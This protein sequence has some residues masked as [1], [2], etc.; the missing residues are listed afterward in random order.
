MHSKRGVPA[1][2]LSKHALILDDIFVGGDENVELG[3]S[4]LCLY[5][6]SVIGR[7]FIRKLE[8]GRRPLLKLQNPVSQRTEKSTDMSIGASRRKLQ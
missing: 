4:H 3:A 7:A 8:N 1:T 5:F 6:T 2:H